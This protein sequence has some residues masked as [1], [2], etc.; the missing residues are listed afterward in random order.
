[1]T[2]NK[3][4]LETRLEILEKELV[5]LKSDYKKLEETHEIYKKSEEKVEGSSIYKIDWP[6]SS[7]NN[8]REDNTDEDSHYWNFSHGII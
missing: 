7:S 6:Q 5:D 1:M 4:I 3:P 8:Y 2:E